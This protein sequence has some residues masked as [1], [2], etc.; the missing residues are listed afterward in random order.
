[1]KTMPIKDF[2][3]PLD[4]YATVPENASLADAIQ[5]LERAQQD[6][7]HSKYRHRAILVL[8]SA[9]Q[10]IGKISQ[11]DALRALEPKYKEIQGEDGGST[12]RHFS[13][14]FLKSMLDRYSL[15]DGTLEEL[16]KK[17]A[18]INVKEFM[19]NLSADDCIDEEASLAEAIHTLVMGR[20]QS[21]LVSR[22]QTI[23]G[24][25]RLTDIFTAVFHTLVQPPGGNR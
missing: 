18:G 16:K 14:M 8:D 21:L 11:I 5:A 10:P 2:I 24:I 20:H 13:R 1:M 6:F 19:H 7:D 17:A 22:D 25:L 23:V 12:F 15:L 4:E 9:G 3:V